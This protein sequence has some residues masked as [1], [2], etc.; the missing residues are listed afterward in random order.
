MD[1]KITL[2]HC[3]DNFNFVDSYKVVDIETEQDYLNEDIASPELKAMIETL[4]DHGY[5]VS[6]N[7]TWY[8]DA[9]ND[10]I[11]FRCDEYRKEFREAVAKIYPQFIDRFNAGDAKVIAFVGDVYLK[12]LRF[13]VEQVMAEYCLFMKSRDCTYS[14]DDFDL[15][16]FIDNFS[17]P[18][19]F[20]AYRNITA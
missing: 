6:I 15:D 18:I 10:A 8:D 16:S 11:E 12:G 17:N 20:D 13:A 4:T 2:R 14:P 7:E 9:L 19:V 1:N 3:I 5:N